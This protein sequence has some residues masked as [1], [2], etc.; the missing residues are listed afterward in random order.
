MGA[1]RQRI[2]NIRQ[3]KE[4]EHREAMSEVQKQQARAFRNWGEFLVGLEDV[5]DLSVRPKGRLLKDSFYCYDP[6]TMRTGAD[7]LGH[8]GRDET[9][10][11]G[12]TTYERVPD[13]LRVTFFICDSR[14]EAVVGVKRALQLVEEQLAYGQDLANLRDEEWMR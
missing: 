13:G 7:G 5:M 4:Q 1:M 10:I 9:L 14:F 12:E 11:V 2:L 8:R 6:Q 3:V